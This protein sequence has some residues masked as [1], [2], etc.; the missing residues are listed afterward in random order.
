M[1]TKDARRIAFMQ[2]RIKYKTKMAAKLA[3]E[4]ATIM[5]NLSGH[6]GSELSRREVRGYTALMQGKIALESAD[7]ILQQKK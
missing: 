6:R 4:A 7:D 3:G 2:A 1:S 5:E